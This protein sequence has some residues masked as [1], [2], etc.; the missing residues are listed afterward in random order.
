MPRKK[1]ISAIDRTGQTLLVLDNAGKAVFTG[2]IGEKTVSIT[3]LAA[4]TKVATGDYKVA[5]T[6][7]TQTSDSVDVPAFEVPA[8]G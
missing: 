1:T 8:E 5:Y 7:G 4:G 3:G 6:D 2:K